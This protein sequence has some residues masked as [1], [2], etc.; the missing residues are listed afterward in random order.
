MLVIQRVNTLYLVIKIVSKD[1]IIQNWKELDGIRGD[2]RRLAGMISELFN[3]M[4]FAKLD[5]ISSLDIF[6]VKGSKRNQREG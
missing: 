2:Y 3:D 4:M 5:I 1:R 6:S